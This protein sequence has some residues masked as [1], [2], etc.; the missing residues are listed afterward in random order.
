MMLLRKI[1]KC[2]FIFLTVISIVLIFCC[3]GL[4]Q[5]CGIGCCILA[6]ALFYP[7]F[8]GSKC[9]Y[10]RITVFLL[11]AAIVAAGLIFISDRINHISGMEGMKMGFLKIE[12]FLFS[13]IL[14]LTTTAFCCRMKKILKTAIPGI[15]FVIYAM[16][17]IFFTSS[18]QANFPDFY[19]LLFGIV[20]L[21]LLLPLNI[22]MSIRIL[23]FTEAKKP[24]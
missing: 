12:I 15:V 10:L 5:S 14:I 6:P 4:L 24:L 2:I 22:I 20:P 19:F 1:L 17:G 8:Y 21:L 23:M 13:T 11:I 3:N 7:A 9:D 16:S 18:A